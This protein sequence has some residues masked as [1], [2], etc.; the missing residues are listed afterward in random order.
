MPE[1]TDQDRAVLDQDDQPIAAPDRTGPRRA[2]L[3]GIGVAL[4]GILAAVLF[5]TT[6]TSGS[7]GKGAT[8]AG[9]V[10]ASG[11][12]FPGIAPATANLLALSPYPAGGRPAPDFHLTDQLGRP[13]SLSQFR[14]RSVVLSFNDDQCTD[15]CTLL[16]EDVVRA[17]EFLGAAG[18]SRVIFLSVN[19]NPFYPGVQY[20]KKW[21][22]DNALGSLP[23]WYFGTGS[24]SDLQA[25]WKAYGVFVGADAK[26][27]SVT[28]GTVLDFIG[29]SGNIQAVGDFGLDAVDVDPYSHGMAQMAVDLLPSSQ[30]NSVAGPQA[31]GA[32]GTGA[33]LGQQAPDF[34]LPILGQAGQELDLAAAR[35]QPVVLNFWA[36]SCP[37]CRDELAAFAQV[38]KEDPKI[39]FVG[40]DVADPSLSAATALAR[41]S[42]IAYPVAVDHGGQVASAYR[43]SG[44][45][46]TIFLSAAG[47]V[48]VFH[49]GALTAEQLRY[50]L[51]QFFPGDA[52][53][54]H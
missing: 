25:I 9:G 3:I 5:S 24:V 21:S 47:K 52:P 31:T 22:D 14:G 13:V 51:A 27:K 43:I 2:L 19:V 4:A 26:D 46:T 45:P 50:S 40:V 36:S 15:V 10:D 30:Q 33:G 20:V 48:A 37:D 18:R 17:D 12:A 38:A 8:G 44:L 29:P 41:Q 6:S 35:G 7:G 49:P 23:N 32:S 39:R 16:A 54:D 42:G 11:A 34:H 28:H 53:R 1:S